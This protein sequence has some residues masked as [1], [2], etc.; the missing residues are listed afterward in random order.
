VDALG[1]IDRHMAPVSPA[2][3]PSN[4]DRRC[5]ELTQS[6]RFHDAGGNVMCPSKLFS[7]VISIL[8]ACSIWLFIP[9]VG[10]GAASAGDI[11][12]DFHAQPIAARTWLADQ[13]FEFKLDATNTSRVRF[14]LDDHGLVIETLGPAEPI[15]AR[16]NLNVPQ[17]S[18][19]TV[20]WGVNRYPAGA[21]WDSA[22][23]NEAIMV[24]IFFGNEKLSG[25]L[26]MPASPYFIGLFLC[27]SGRRGVALTGRSYTTQGRYI[28]V[29][30]PAA[31]KETTSVVALDETFRAAFHAATT[32]PVTGFAIEADTS[33]LGAEARSSA[34]TKSI[35][36]SSQNR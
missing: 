32:P 1:G 29:D 25:G 6:F 12:Y 35:K 2:L 33:Q 36:I 4:I 8:R 27:E 9:L 30:G 23:H 15:L 22:A 31:G 3:S 11:S 7:L 13:G 14:G 10:A 5:R 16:P 24:M 20:T 18:Q 34:W 26:F 19:L 17:P 28:C 21:N